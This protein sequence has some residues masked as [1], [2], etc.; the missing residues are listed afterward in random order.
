MSQPTVLIAVDFATHASEICLGALPLIQQLEARV[1]LLHMMDAGPMVSPKTLIQPSGQTSPVP[2][3][4]HLEADAR[5]HL[6]P[7]MSIFEEVGVAVRLE[8]RHGDVVSGIWSCAE[9]A[10][11]A[12]VVIGSDV[13]EG[14]RRL[15]SASFT[16]AVLRQASRP[17][18]VVKA[19]P[20]RKAPGLSE[21]REQVM[22]EADG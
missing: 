12:M 20:Q 18:L 15:L 7:L 1:L 5:E 10:D 9:A 19:R 14:L 21:A 6:T 4:K 8:L 11:A 2:V 3:A 22:A 17:V 16:D 13:P